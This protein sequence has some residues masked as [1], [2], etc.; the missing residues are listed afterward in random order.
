MVTAEGVEEV[1]VFEEAGRARVEYE[2]EE[3]E[4][5]GEQRSGDG[6]GGGDGAR[7]GRWWC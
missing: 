4:E 5:E 7:G 6:S 2:E 3:G 1:L